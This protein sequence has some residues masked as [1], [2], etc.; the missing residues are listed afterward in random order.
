MAFSIG[1]NVDSNLI[2][3]DW[4]GE[5]GRRTWW[6]IF[7]QEV[8]LSVDCGRPMAISNSDIAVELPE[9]YSVVGKTVHFASQLS[10]PEQP[11]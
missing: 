4:D 1:L 9:D 10:Y 7:I 6:M 2:S 8:E 5:E 3:H 11:N